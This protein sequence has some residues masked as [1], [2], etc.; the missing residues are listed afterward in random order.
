MAHRRSKSRRRSD[1]ELKR[2][3]GQHAIISRVG[4][5]NLIHLD[6]PSPEKIR[7]R[8]EEVKSETF[9]AEE[10][11]CPLCRMQK[12]MGGEIVYSCQDWCPDCEK[13]ESCPSYNPDLEDVE[14]ELELAEADDSRPGGP[15]DPNQIL[16]PWERS[17]GDVTAVAFSPPRQA[18]FLLAHIVGGHFPEF[19][20]DLKELGAPE[21][22]LLEF[23]AT[24]WD[25]P[26]M[27]VGFLEGARGIEISGIKAAIAKTVELIAPF[28]KEES[29]QEKAQDLRKKLVML[30]G[31]LE[32]IGSE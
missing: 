8:I 1:A 16:S 7:Q 15:L 13:K 5:Y 32:R 27:V 23:K 11:D 4:N 14:R 22:R 24:A 3:Y 12:E 28:E 31:I 20:D 10:D 17:Y 6:Y 9:Q 19:R 26:G 18:A 29:V 25:I 2:I 30:R 21:E